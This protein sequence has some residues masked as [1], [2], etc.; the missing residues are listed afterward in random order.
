VSSQSPK[1]RKAG[2]RN[3]QKSGNQNPKIRG[4]ITIDEKI[5]IERIRAFFRWVIIIAVMFL[6]S[7]VM[8][9]IGGVMPLLMIPF[10]VSVSA[11]ETP[12]SSAIFS[13]LCGLI[14]DNITG[15]LFGFNGILL[16]WAGLGV[17]LL[18][19]LYLRRH[20]LNVFMINA[21]VLA[22]ILSLH[23]LFYVGIWGYDS[24]G[25]VFTGWYIPTFF[26]SGIA[27]LPIYYFLKLLTIKLGK[28]TD[29]QIEEKTD[30]VV[31]E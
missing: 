6:S 14:L 12:Q 16:L 31:R 28:I 5:R 15:A 19:T 10:A 3:N 13:A 7:V 29:L 9:T 2:S 11:F 22:L 20:F 24:G 25:G 4:N 26:W 23:Y 8:W 17:S 30:N 1:F 27:V 18:F 21:L